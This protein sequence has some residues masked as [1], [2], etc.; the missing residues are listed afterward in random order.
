MLV[1]SF[2]RFLIIIALSFHGVFAF[3][4]EADSTNSEILKDDPSLAALDSMFLAK[5]FES[6]DFTTDTGHTC[7]LSRFHREFHDFWY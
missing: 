6:S 3:A 7:Q 1:K 4:Q 2:L 5:W